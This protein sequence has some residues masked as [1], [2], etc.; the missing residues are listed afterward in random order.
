METGGISALQ[1]IFWVVAANVVVI[2][3]V[4]GLVY[5]L[6]KQSQE[7]VQKLARRIQGFDEQMSGLGRFF[8]SYAGI[9][10]E[11]FFTP[12]DELQ[13]EAGQIETR[14]NRFLETCRA[15][16]ED[17]RQTGENKF[18][19][20]INAPFIWFR[21]WQRAQELRREADQIG[22]LMGQIE[23]RTQHIFELPWELAVECRQASKEVAEL[24]QHTQWLQAKGARGMALTRIASQV[25]L[26]NQELER[27][28]AD[29]FDADKDEL[30]N[31]AD[32][33]TSIHV[34]DRLHTIRP[35]VTRYLPQVKE[36]RASYEKA[37]A[38]Y[39]GLKQ[40]GAS[41]RQAFANPPAGLVI[42]PLQERLD[43]VAQ[44]A[45]ELNQRLAQPE[46]EH[47]KT[48]AR[49]TSHL[50]KVLQDTGRQFSQAGEQV[51]G[52]N[53]ALAKLQDGLASLTAQFKAAEQAR[54]YP[55]A[56][57]ESRRALD[58][59]GGQFAALGPVQ[60]PRTPEQVH[61][62]RGAAEGLLAGYQALAAK[63]PQRLK[64]HAA[65][66]ELLN[67][68]PVQEGP[69]W[70]RQARAA[71][72]GA[73]GYDPKNWS[74]TDS[75]ASLPGELDALEKLQTR[76]AP[77]DPGA[78]VLESE[79]EQRLKD[80]QQ[81]AALHKSL[82][83]RV[84][85]IR[86]R[87]EKLQ[88]LEKEG[89]EKLT[90]AWNILER[91]AILSE[92]NER[93]DEL[94]S[95]E[96]DRL[97][98]EIRALGNELNAHQQGEIEKKAE[99]IQAQADKVNQALGQWLAGLNSAIAGR[100]K[101]T[102][103]LLIRLDS[104]ASIDE[105]PIAAARALLAREEVAALRS[106]APAA[107]LPKNIVGRVTNRLSPA[108]TKPPA[109]DELDALAEIKRK[110]DLWQTLLAAQA[111]LEEKSKPLLAANQ[112]VVQARGEAQERLVELAKRLPGRRA[113]PPTNQAPLSEN[114]ALRDGDEKREG[115]KKRPGGVETA[116]REL[117]RAARDYRLAAEHAQQILD[118]IDQD[119]E[120][121]QELEWQINS[122]K[123]RWQSQVEPDN[124]IMREG[125][126]HLLS[127]A[128]SG[129]SAI[130]QKYMQGLLSYEEV[131]RSLQLLYDDTFSAQVPVDEQNKVR[132]NE[133]HRRAEQT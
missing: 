7:M 126:R 103:D 23:N 2:A 116:V 111:A 89:K 98:E 56:W 74:K 4:I 9:D 35:A 58:D 127:Q 53:Q 17:I 125:V 114:E 6:R 28:P 67:S 41:L 73:G 16:E 69:P 43:Q 75:L 1:I 99:K 50:N 40:A 113:W 8:Q 26:L 95:T 60:Q 51:A 46:V 30:L 45:S 101:E 90:G 34:F 83:P 93:L 78:P 65:L 68:Q 36:W 61:Q 132:L 84:E 128:D 77:P 91:V 110:N 79:L 112:E 15:F 70:L 32:L 37:S 31:R 13:S 123:E 122:L 10:Q 72:A 118:R 81:L 129:L 21:R 71:A 62:Q 119:Q 104:V 107:G 97:G 59:L 108:E 96:I 49:E 54:R 55:L 47:L 76:L 22:G 106:A 63:A 18:Q 133:P 44:M 94:V 24:A 33:R 87:L 115:L 82:R 120:R 19:N 39:A 102:A 66:V 11:P 20:V 86:E 38:E 130:K 117:G 48:L 12:L 5:W 100:V 88:A 3:S 64:Q 92:S 27:V 85:R 109:F 105:P 80:T 121:I 29:Y 14:L 25:P 124:L 42:T 131:I 57:D 52:L